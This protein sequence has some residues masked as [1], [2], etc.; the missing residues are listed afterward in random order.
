VRS[1]YGLK[2]YQS[3]AARTAKKFCHGTINSLKLFLQLS[4]NVSN[5]WQS[6]SDAAWRRSPGRGCGSGAFLQTRYNTQSLQ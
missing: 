1:N 6:R 4:G 3:A 2:S 5:P